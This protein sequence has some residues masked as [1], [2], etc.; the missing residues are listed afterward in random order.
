MSS[1]VAL[2]WLDSDCCSAEADFAFAVAVDRAPSGRAEKE[3]LSARSDMQMAV[4]TY[5]NSSGSG[6]GREDSGVRKCWTVEY[7]H[8][9][10]SSSFARPGADYTDR[11]HRI[12][13][14]MSC[15]VGCSYCSE[16]QRHDSHCYSSVA[17]YSPH[18][19]ECCCRR[20]R[21]IGSQQ[22]RWNWETTCSRS[23]RADRCS[24]SADMTD[25][26]RDRS[27]WGAAHIETL[28]L[29]T[30]SFFSSAW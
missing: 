1:D 19:A 29:T 22:R 28:P 4:Q 14:Q 8:T 15:T 17:Q 11:F 12:C 10:S 5:L 3:G 25:F 23:S 13:S 26:Q 20:Y 18:T 7:C 21:H 30:P 24:R 16:L 27:S 6:S 9:C 2:A